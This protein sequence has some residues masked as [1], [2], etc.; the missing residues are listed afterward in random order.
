MSAKLKIGHCLFR[1]REEWM[2]KKIEEQIKIMRQLAKARRE[3]ADRAGCWITR[4]RLRQDADELEKQ[5]KEL[6]KTNK[7]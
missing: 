4:D 2:E 1:P 3:A 7:G 5:A 6:E